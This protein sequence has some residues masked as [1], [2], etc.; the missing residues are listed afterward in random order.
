M[1]V[2]V[3]G[4]RG[5]VPTSR[6]PASKYGGNTTCMSLESRGHSL[7]I[8]AGSGLAQLDR[9]TKIFARTDDPIDILIGHLHLDHLVGLSVFGPVWDP[10]DF[11]RV[12][13]C[14]RDERPLKE[15]IFSVFKPPYW[16]VSMVDAANAECTAIVNGQPFDVGSFTVTPFAAG[17]PDETASFY[18][19]DGR[20]TVVHLLDSEVSLLDGESYKEL[21]DYCKGADLV[22]FDAAYSP[23]DYPEKV[24]WGHSTIEDGRKLAVASGCSKIMFSHFSFEYSDQELEVLE[25]RAKSWGDQYF[26]AR[27]GMEFE[28]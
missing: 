15:Q 2:K 25:S 4:C 27:D 12:F 8:D 23:I 5:S 1:R 17:H 11:V 20:K 28:L 16:P 6:S 26:F 13:T 10:K 24:G 3:Y 14:S 19:T 22:V 21:V 7:I 18:V 9:L